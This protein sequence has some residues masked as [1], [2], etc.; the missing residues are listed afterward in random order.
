MARPVFAICAGTLCRRAGCLGAPAL[1]VY[2]LSMAGP[3][4]SARRSAGLRR[5]PQPGTVGYADRSASCV[6]P[7]YALLPFSPPKRRAEG[8]WQFR[9][10]YAVKRLRKKPGFRADGFRCSRNLRKRPRK[11][12]FT[13]GRG[14]PFF[15]WQPPLVTPLRK[16]PTWGAAGEKKDGCG[17]FSPHPWGTIG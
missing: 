2:G 1:F 11:P 9:L 7:P 16:C 6:S 13:R 15:A 12:S 10:V 5:A 4:P 3:L 8:R 14:A 17:D